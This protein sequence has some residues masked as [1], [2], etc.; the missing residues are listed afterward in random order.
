MQQSDTTNAVVINDTYAK[1]LGFLDPQKAVGKQLKWNSN[2]F[3]VGVVAD[4]HPRSLH[5][6]I[7]PILIANGTNRARC[8]N[9]ELQP[10]VVS[11]SSWPHTIAAI[12]SAWKSVYPND[13]FEYHFIDD[14]IAKFYD[15]EKYTARLLLWSTGLTIF[16]SCLGLLGL[17]IYITN[18]RTKEI[19]IRKVIGA[20]VMQIIVLLS[21]DFM[22]L[23]AL[24]ILIALPIAWWG[25][26][27][28]L[29][30]YAYRTDISWW[31]F[32]AGG[33]LLLAIA[34]LILC[35]RTFRAAV[36]N[37]VESLRSE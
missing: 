35:L 15:A 8:F 9:I 12:E 28:W 22:K 31:I 10:E 32:A 2:P 37:P 36:V 17:I 33:G 13:D 23:I 4:F 1:R 5:E 21:R 34:L 24:A 11:G 6:P 14:T 18:V 3:I 25:G 30:N 20:S 16:I 29:D 19:G 7:K 27:K 26:R